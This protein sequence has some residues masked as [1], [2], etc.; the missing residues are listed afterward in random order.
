MPVKTVAVARLNAGVSF[1]LIFHVRKSVLHVQTS[2]E[3]WTIPDGSSEGHQGERKR[4]SVSQFLFFV[5]SAV[6]V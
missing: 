5:K 6:E 2:L 3:N 1:V 4:L